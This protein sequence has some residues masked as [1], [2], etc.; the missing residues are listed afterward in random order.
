MQQSPL[1]GQPRALDLQQKPLDLQQNVLCAPRGKEWVLQIY[2]DL[3]HPDRSGAPGKEWRRR[4]AADLQRGLRLLQ[5]NN[6]D[7]QHV[8]EG[9]LHISV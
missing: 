6:V 1:S 8:N 7:S 2:R 9:L 4:G 3:Q 5:Q